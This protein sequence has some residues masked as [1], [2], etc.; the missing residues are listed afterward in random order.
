MYW[1]VK[2]L[3]TFLERKIFLYSLYFKQWEIF[4]R[5][6]FISLQ[7]LAD[8]KNYILILQNFPQDYDEYEEG[9]ESQCWKHLYRFGKRLF[10]I[11]KYM[12]FEHVC[13]NTGENLRGRFDCSDWIRYHPNC[14]QISF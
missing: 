7:I 11:E 12:S 10:L 4:K 13:L 6:A 3:M 14:F 8:K 1:S 9:V 5:D 2:P